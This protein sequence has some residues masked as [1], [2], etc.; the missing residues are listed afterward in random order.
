M[1]AAS[2][3]MGPSARLPA[4]R[5]TKIYTTLAVDSGVLR[6]DN[7]GPLMRA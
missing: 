6:H 7:E 1:T 3:N 5:I 2:L 4:R